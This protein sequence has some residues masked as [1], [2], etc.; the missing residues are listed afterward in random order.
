VELK[1]EKTPLRSTPAGLQARP[2]SKNRL[3]R[4]VS[5]KGSIEKQYTLNDHELA[6]IELLWAT[7]DEEYGAFHARF[8]AFNDNRR[9]DAR[10]ENIKDWRGTQRNQITPREQLWQNMN[11]EVV[12]YNRAEYA[13][14]YFCTE[15]Y[16]TEKKVKYD[17]THVREDYLVENSQ[18]VTETLSRFGT[19]KNIFVHQAFPNGPTKVVLCCRWFQTIT[20]SD[21]ITGLAVVQE[22][23]NLPENTKDKFTFLETVYQV[24]V[25]VW[26]Y[27]PFKK[28]KGNDERRTYFN[29][30]DRNQDQ[31]A[32]SP[33]DV[34]DADS[35][36]DADEADSNN[37]ADSDSEN[38]DDNAE[39]IADEQN[40][41][42]SSWGC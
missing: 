15:K 9:P 37:D 1:W 25:A 22:K 18:G 35:V 36:D 16:Q 10:L 12:M 30:I 26:K 8:V 38:A 14:N 33:A 27:R 19:I 28:F 41:Y 17:N 11:R 21:A 13:G 20:Q 29:I 23:R 39:G 42:I 6:Q 24:P 4:F 7:V 3:D 34:S 31:L 2:K 40:H 5:T 32:Y